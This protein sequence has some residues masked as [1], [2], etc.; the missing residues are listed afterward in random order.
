[1]DKDVPDLPYDQYMESLK[2]KPPTFTLSDDSPFK[3]KIS[4]YRRIK[5]WW[6]NLVHRRQLK[7][8]VAEIK[9][10]RKA[11]GLWIDRIE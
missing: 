7:K 10:E 9:A 5:H 6:R 11:K 8:A 3:Y 1:M 2:P 4:F